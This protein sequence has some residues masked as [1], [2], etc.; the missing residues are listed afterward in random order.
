MVWIDDFPFPREA[1]ILRFQPLISGV[2]SHRESFKPCSDLHVLD[3][4]CKCT[5]MRCRPWIP[6]G[7]WK[8]GVFVWCKTFTH[9]ITLDPKSLGWVDST[10]KGWMGFLLDWAG[11]N[12][13]IVGCG[14]TPTLRDLFFVGVLQKL[15]KFTKKEPSEAENINFTPHFSLGIL[16]ISLREK[17][18][19]VSHRIHVTGIFYLHLIDVYGKCR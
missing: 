3:I 8:Q 16:P 9:V 4:R 2:P 11:W 19:L 13:E 15:Q 14:N 5:R 17:K 7:G 18:Q 10:T 1:R 12:E 6:P